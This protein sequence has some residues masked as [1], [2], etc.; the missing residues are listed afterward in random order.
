MAIETGDGIVEANHNLDVLRHALADLPAGPILADEKMRIESL[1]AAAWHELQGGNEEAMEGFKLH[2]RSEN[3][4]WQPPFLRFTI[5]RHGG[6]VLGSTRAALHRW[7]VNVESGV[8]VL[9][10]T[11]SFRQ[12]AP[13]AQPLRVDPV[14]AEV[15]RAIEHHQ[16]HPALEWRTPTRVR[17]VASRVEGLGEGFSQTIAGRRRRFTTALDQQLAILGWSRLPVHGRFEYENATMPA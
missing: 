3:L 16:E 7:E 9:G 15:V 8:A 13:R 14:V 17:V 5:E 2:G 4:I 11:S 1:L 12:V 10:D 6:T